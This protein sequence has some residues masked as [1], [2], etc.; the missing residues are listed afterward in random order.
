MNRE[1][2]IRVTHHLC[3]QY[4]DSNEKEYRPVQLASLALI[5]AFRNLDLKAPDHAMGFAYQTLTRAYLNLIFV[6]CP[7]D[8]V[9]KAIEFG[10]MALALHPFDDPNRAMIM[11]TLAALYFKQYEIGNRD[12]ATKR[13]KI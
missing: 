13:T 4:W 1:E 8:L 10:R 5:W 12:N 2:V 7:E 6:A 11:N 9:Q 3:E